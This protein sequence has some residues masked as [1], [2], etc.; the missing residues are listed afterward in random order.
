MNR[1]TFAP[2]VRTII[3]ALVLIP[4]GLLGTHGLVAP[5]HIGIFSF[6]AASVVTLL[7]T[8]FRGI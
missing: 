6:L 5:K 2:T 8:V 1:T 4:V 3:V 7:G